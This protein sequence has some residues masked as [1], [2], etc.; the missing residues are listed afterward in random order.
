MRSLAPR[1][2]SL[3]LK[4]DLALVRE[5]EKEADENETKFKTDLADAEEN[6]GDVEVKNCLL[7][8]AEFL[9]KTGDKERALEAYEKA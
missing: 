8:R 5:L 7:D 6:A 9:N 4:V 3:R 1:C 2:E